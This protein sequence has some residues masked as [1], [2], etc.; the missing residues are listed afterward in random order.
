MNSTKEND[1]TNEESSRISKDEEKEESKKDYFDL[2][3]RSCS[4]ECQPE[5]TATVSG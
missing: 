1:P 3:L 5:V 4:K 2:Y